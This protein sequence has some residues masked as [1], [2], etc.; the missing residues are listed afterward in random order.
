MNWLCGFNVKFCELCEWLCVVIVTHTD[1]CDFC[2]DM[3]LICHVV[4]K[5]VEK[6]RLTECWFAAGK[7]NPRQL[8][9]SQR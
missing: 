5:I 9:H 1:V 3:Y 2:D 4:Y 6:M 7:G 8:D